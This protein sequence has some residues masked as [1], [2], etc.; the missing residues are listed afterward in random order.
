MSTLDEA[1]LDDGC[2]QGDTS[3][4]EQV[5]P[6]LG[7]PQA[8][9]RGRAAEML[10][11]APWTALSPYAHDAFRGAPEGMWWFVLA[12]RAEASRAP[13]GAAQDAAFMTALSAKLESASGMPADPLFAVARIAPS[14]PPEARDRL[15]PV[16]VLHPDDEVSVVAAM[17]LERPLR[18]DEVARLAQIEGR[19]A[20]DALVARVQGGDASA[21]SA[22]AGRVLH[23]GPLAYMALEALERLPAAADLAALRTIW[24]R[25]WFVQPVHVR[26]ADV[27]L[28]LGD[29]GARAALESWCDHR[30]PAVRA[31]ALAALLTHAATDER[32]DWAGRIVGLGRATVEDVVETLRTLP[33]SEAVRDA[34]AILSQRSSSLR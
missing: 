26:A 6:L 9:T 29:E 33:P 2:A 25:R 19:F 8:Y 12:H 20:T 28:R 7:H 11:H 10:A 3:T 31:T 34:I 15:S 27:A 21:W 32:R 16:L 30:K 18:T 4:L 24:D 13:F 23:A 14:L 17:G 5:I 22:L 1:A